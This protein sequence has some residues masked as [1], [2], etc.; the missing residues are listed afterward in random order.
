LKKLNEEQGM[1]ILVSSH[2]LSELG[3]PATCYGFINKGRMI[4]Q[5]TTEEQVF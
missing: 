5:I 3:Q 4:E 1:A 2:I